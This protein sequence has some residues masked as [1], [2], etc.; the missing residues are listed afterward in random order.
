MIKKIPLIK[1][2]KKGQKTSG[3]KKPTAESADW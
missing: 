1:T 3:L 2:Q